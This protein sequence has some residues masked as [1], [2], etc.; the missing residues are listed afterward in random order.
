LRTPAPAFP[1]A[2]SAAGEQSFYLFCRFHRAIA[3]G[4]LGLAIVR[5]RSRGRTALSSPVERWQNGLGTRLVAAVFSPDDGGLPGLI[6]RAGRDPANRVISLDIS[7][8]AIVSL[9]RRV[10]RYLG[11]P[12]S[13]LAFRSTTRPH[14]RSNAKVH[15]DASLITV[16]TIDPPIFCFHREYLSFRLRDSGPIDSTSEFTAC[17]PPPP[18]PP[19]GTCNSREPKPSERTQKL[20]QCVRARPNLCSGGPP[21]RAGWI[22]LDGPVIG[23]LPPWER[24]GIP[25]VQRG[26][27]RPCEFYSPDNGITAGL[28]LGR[29]GFRPLACRIPITFLCTTLPDAST[30]PACPVVTI[31]V[32]FF[33]STQIRPAQPRRRGATIAE[34]A[35]A[36]LPDMLP[37]GGPGGAPDF[38]WLS[39]SWKSWFAPWWPIPCWVFGES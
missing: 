23:N 27:H 1:E 14:P 13:H 29:E 25:E 12:M 38:A 21:G 8:K 36:Y 3:S 7:P 26:F 6:G 5:P 11:P 22:V 33:P 9:S 35:V 32:R 4:P 39:P 20:S 18:L 17:W 19:P 31:V 10:R 2:P 30:A 24:R 28:R 16:S 15:A 37:A 34:A